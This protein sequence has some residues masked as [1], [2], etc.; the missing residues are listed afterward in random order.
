MNKKR[1]IA[2]LIKIGILGI[3]IFLMYYTLIVFDTRNIMRDI[4][5]AKVG[6][7][8]KYE[9]YE[10]F[11]PKRTTVKHKTKRYFTWCWGNKGEIWLTYESTTV[12]PEGKKMVSR[13]YCSLLIEKREGRWE[14]IKVKYEP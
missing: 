5:Q 12:L 3:V 13:D 11:A 8:V 10:K 9:I 4:K 6:N 1:A 2:I 14:A 7:E